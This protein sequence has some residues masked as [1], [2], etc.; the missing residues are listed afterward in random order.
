MK[1]H[2]KHK[3]HVYKKNTE[4]HH[5][6]QDSTLFHIDMQTILVFGKY[7]IKL[8]SMAYNSKIVATYMIHVTFPLTC[9]PLVSAKFTWTQQIGTIDPLSSANNCQGAIT[10]NH[11]P[12]H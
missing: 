6:E 3:I 5:V 12:V 8:A 11:G 9:S 4:T 1:S 10:T 2:Y 7:T